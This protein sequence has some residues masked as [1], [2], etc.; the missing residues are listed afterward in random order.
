MQG[1]ACATCL[2]TLVAT[3]AVRAHGTR[4]T[5]QARRAPGI[6]DAQLLFSPYK[7]VSQAIEP[8][9]GILQT[10]VT[11][12]TL[13]LVGK[14]G[15]VATALPGLHAITLAFATGTCS[16]ERWGKLTGVQFA[17]ANIP[18]LNAAGL[19]YII[20]TGGGD[21]GKFTCATPQAFLRF[22]ARYNGPHLLGVDFDIESGQTAAEVRA[23]V[24]D[25]AAAAQRYPQ[26]RFTFTLATFAGADGSHD[27]LNALGTTVVNAIQASPLQHYVINL[28]VMDYDHPDTHQCV[29]SRGT[30]D[31]GRSALQAVANL[32]YR[33][34]IPA[35]KIALTPMIGNNDTPGQY[36][37][38]ADLDTLLHFAVSRHLAGVHFWSLD[39]DRPCTA[40]DLRMPAPATGEAPSTCNTEPGATPLAYTRRA[41]RD[42]GR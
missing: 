27:S 33:F 25:A 5:P 41:L 38:L 11:G 37:T 8:A 42:L 19:D 36:F 13:P 6:P 31:M 7:D 9:T 3:P 1:L 34:G 17:R 39:R 12:T 16:D 18:A 24:A 10:H 4:A 14:G 35:R 21:G 30:C 40:A 15:L 29:V 26:L 28:M 22:V 2:L 20:S 32:E 23:L